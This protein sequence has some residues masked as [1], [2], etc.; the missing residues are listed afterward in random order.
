MIIQS[1][2]MQLVLN[3]DQIVGYAVEE[4]LFSYY[5][6]PYR[7]LAWSAEQG[8]DYILGEYKTKE[9]AQVILDGFA[10]CLAAG[11]RYFCFAAEDLEDDNEA[12]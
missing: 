11:V 8:I 12:R 9:E 5:E 10:E 3:S 7:I 4:R 1:Q 2:N 6:R